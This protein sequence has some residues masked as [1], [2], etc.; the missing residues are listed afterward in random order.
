MHFRN[1]LLEIEERLGPIIDE[2][3]LE[4][5]I[6]ETSFG[7]FVLYF[8]IVDSAGAVWRAPVTFI[9][10]SSLGEG[11]K[12]LDW[13]RVKFGLV[14]PKVQPVGTNG[15][16]HYFGEPDNLG[17]PIDENGTFPTLDAA[18][19]I[20]AHALRNYALVPVGTHLPNVVY[21]SDIAELWQQLELE[22]HARGI[23]VVEF[24]RRMDNAEFLSFTLADLRIE[25]IAHLQDAS[26]TVDGDVV[27]ATSRG[28]EV[29]QMMEE[30]LWTMEDI[31]ADDSQHRPH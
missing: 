14:E 3:G 19:A 25:I 10:P 4:Q 8:E 21:N 7:E 11:E 24:G 16:V 12:D 22:C 2:L 13:N 18:F 20:F 31:V 28:L 15:W 26:I 30:L 5:R 29:H 23:E 9:F 27:Y 1:C 17:E 6:H